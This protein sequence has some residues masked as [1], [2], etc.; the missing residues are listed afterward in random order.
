M[1]VDVRR[2]CIYG[3]FAVSWSFAV[4]RLRALRALRARVTEKREPQL[5][6][7]ALPTQPLPNGYFVK[8]QAM[9]AGRPKGPLRCA[10]R[11]GSEQHTSQQDTSQGLGWP[12]KKPGGEATFERPDV[13]RLK[14]GKAVVPAAARAPHVRPSLPPAPGPRDEGAHAPVVQEARGRR[15]PGACA[16]AQALCSVAGSRRGTAPCPPSSLDHGP[17]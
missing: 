10:E 8:M 1:Y 13:R 6:A 7:D 12:H 15:A 4:A 9:R 14:D 2:I 11:E 17:P 5:V 16:P 3:C